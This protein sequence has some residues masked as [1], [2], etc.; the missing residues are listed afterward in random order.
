M[1]ASLLNFVLK[2]LLYCVYSGGMFVPQVLILSL[3]STE[4]LLP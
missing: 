1:T 2:L 3:A 4:K